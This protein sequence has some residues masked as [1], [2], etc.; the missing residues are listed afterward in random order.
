M[1]AHGEG[2]LFYQWIKDG[3][4][5]SDKNIPN[6]S[7][8]NSPVLVIS[9]FS[10]EHEGCYKCVVRNEDITLESSDAHLKGNSSI[11]TDVDGS[12]K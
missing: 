9:S 11:N 1:S 7:G 10:S 2:A 4:A 8:C 5:I 6:C 12:Q 3:E